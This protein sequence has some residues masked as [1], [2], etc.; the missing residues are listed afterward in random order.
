MVLVGWSGVL[1]IENDS[2]QHTIFCLHATIMGV[3]RIG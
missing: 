2:N 3:Y 1:V